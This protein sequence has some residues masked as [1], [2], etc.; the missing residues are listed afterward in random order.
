MSLNA[1][2]SF[3]PSKRRRVDALE[4]V[5]LER[6]HESPLQRFSPRGSSSSG[7]LLTQKIWWFFLR[8]KTL[9]D[10]LR[11]GYE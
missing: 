7:V 8:L 2:D 9:L 11:K 1:E 5:S 10:S 4:F 6:T 3:S